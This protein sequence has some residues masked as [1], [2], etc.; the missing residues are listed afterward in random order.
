MLLPF[1]EA[2]SLLWCG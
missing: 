1:K 2:Y